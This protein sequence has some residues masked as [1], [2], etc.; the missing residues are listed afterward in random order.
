MTSHLNED[1]NLSNYKILGGWFFG[2]LFGGVRPL[3]LVDQLVT[4]FVIQV[5]KHGG[6]E[7]KT[8]RTCTR[9]T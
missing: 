4:Q 6:E 9:N 2:K 3:L 7:V 5:D 8:D 1:S